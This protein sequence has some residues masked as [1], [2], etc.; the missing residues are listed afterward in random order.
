MPTMKIKKKNKSLWDEILKG[1][2]LLSEK[3]ASNMEK[4][5]KKFRK[6]RGFRQ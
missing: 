1:P 3:E 6:E 2:T 5:V 4:I